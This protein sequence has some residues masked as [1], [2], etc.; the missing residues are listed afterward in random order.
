MLAY[1]IV[2]SAVVEISF[3]EIREWNMFLT[4]VR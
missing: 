1:R 4:F 2:V 3:F